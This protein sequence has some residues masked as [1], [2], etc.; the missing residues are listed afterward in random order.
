MGCI[1]VL[2]ALIL[3]RVAL[4][5]IFLFTQWLQAAYQTWLWPV[6]GFIFM[7]YTTLA[8]MAA[9]LNTNGGITPG[10]LIV[11]ILAVLADVDTGAAAIVR[12]GVAWWSCTG[13]SAAAGRRIADGD[14]EKRW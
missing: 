12:A 8:Y 11:I 10:W 6:L 9:V 4:A 13:K 7:P 1:L 5:L 14:G 3:P 2:V